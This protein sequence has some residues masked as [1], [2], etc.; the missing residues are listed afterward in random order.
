[1]RTKIK[2]NI[3]ISDDT[4][5]KNVLFGYNDDLAEEIADNYQRC[6]SGKFS[7]AALGSE[8]LPLGDVTSVRGILVI[9]DDNFSYIMNG[10]AD[11]ITCQRAGTATTSKCRVLL[12]ATVSQFAI[13]NPSA[14]AA[15]TGTWVAW[16]DLTV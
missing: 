14:T 9:A 3:V 1:M 10:G 6:V 16:G 2:A 8:N 5:G 13:T 15:L 4:A 11:T 7:V 12:Q